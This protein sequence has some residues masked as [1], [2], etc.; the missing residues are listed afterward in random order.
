MIAR[1]GP[2]PLGGFARTTIE[3]V[4]P[5]PEARPAPS[6]SQLSEPRPYWLTPLHW[7]AYW[8]LKRTSW[9][10]LAPPLGPIERDP[11]SSRVSHQGVDSRHPRLARMNRKAEPTNGNVCT[12]ALSIPYSVME[13]VM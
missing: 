12:S 6:S 9:T 11:P 10:K 4:T 7:K 3:R 2:E 5:V 8:P 13:L 1:L